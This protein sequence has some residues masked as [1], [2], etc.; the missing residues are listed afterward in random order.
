MTPIPYSLAASYVPLNWA[1]VLWAYEKGLIDWNFPVKKA[2]E[3]ILDDDRGAVNTLAWTDK[4]QASVV[5]D[6]LR[7]LAE[8]DDGALSCR[9]WL[10]IVL[11]YIYRN[12]DDPR[13]GLGYIEQVYADFDYPHTIEHFVRY[14][15]N[16]RIHHMPEEKRADALVS[17]WRE[18][19]ASEEIALAQKA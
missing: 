7:Q 11:L 13:D 3:E 14:M 15:P 5:G 2:E 19:L 16:E 12:L 17:N 18:F 9:K 8:H 1:D 4:E 10:A 6:Y